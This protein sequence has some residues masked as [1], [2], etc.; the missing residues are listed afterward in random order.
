MNRSDQATQPKQN[1]SAT[2]H[3]NDENFEIQTGC[4]I[5]LTKTEICQWQKRE[6]KATLTLV[7]CQWKHK[8]RHLFREKLGEVKS[9]PG[10]GIFTPSHSPWCATMST[11]LGKIESHLNGWQK[12]VGRIMNNHELAY[13]TAVK[14]EVTIKC[15][16][17]CLVTQS[18]LT[19]RDP[20]TVALQAPLSMRFS[21]Q[22]YWSGLPFLFPEDLLDP[23]I[24]P[25]SPA[26]AGRFFT[27][28][29][30]MPALI[31]Q[32]GEGLNHNSKL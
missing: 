14:T 13:C 10:N 6:T 22:E 17:A 24:Q 29:I 5:K 16:R 3:L 9:S 26:L 28:T 20:W 27:T 23:G 30:S 8:L 15:V 2:H 25:T 19:F 31:N 18:C 4:T 1:P 21:R 32:S 7:N 12:R 11:A